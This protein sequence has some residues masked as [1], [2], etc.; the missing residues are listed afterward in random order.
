M[1]RFAVIGIGHFGST[2]ARTLFDAGAEVIVVDN[3]KDIIQD[4]TEFSTQ[5]IHADATEKR[6]L[7][8]LGLEDVD[9]A[10]VS[11]GER[12]DVITLVALHLIEIGVPYTSVKALSADHAKILKAIGVSD[13]IH[14]EEESAIR[15]ATRLSLNNVIDFLPMIS[16]YSVVSMLATPLAIGKRI[17][18]LETMDVQ[19]VAIQH[20]ESEKPTLIPHDEEIIKKGDVLILIGENN[21]ITKIAERYCEDI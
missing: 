2:V 16:G 10:I 12:M 1:K 5:A 8:S 20:K 7:Q 4:A 13:I 6:A 14:P 15:L 11:L 19:I 9:V 21:E 17:S 18:D 3:D